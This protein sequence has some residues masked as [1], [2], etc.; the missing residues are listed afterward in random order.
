VSRHLYQWVKS[1]DEGGPDI[2]VS[3]TREGFPSEIVIEDVTLLGGGEQ[4]DYRPTDADY[5]AMESHARGTDT[6]HREIAYI[7]R[8]R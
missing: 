8:A 2:V 5:A 3:F 1:D 4:T 6:Y 7:G